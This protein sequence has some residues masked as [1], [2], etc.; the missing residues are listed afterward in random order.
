MSDDPLF[1]DQLLASLLG[2]PLL[3]KNEIQNA[4]S[5]AVQTQ[6][7]DHQRKKGAGNSVVSGQYFA[8]T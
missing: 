8:P 7:P 1:C 4:V 3:D 5:I 6:E 2:V